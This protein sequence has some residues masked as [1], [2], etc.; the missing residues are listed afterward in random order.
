MHTGG[1]ND[2]GRFPIHRAFIFTDAA[3]SALFFFHNRTLLLITHDGVI[4]ALLIADKADFFRIPGDAS[5][6][7]N[8]GHTHLD[9]AFLFYEKRPDRLGGANPSTKIAEFLTVT[10]T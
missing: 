4:R 8:M 1:I 2:D 5:C 9:K 7:V 6:L 3:A 10:D